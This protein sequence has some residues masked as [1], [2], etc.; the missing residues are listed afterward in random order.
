MY[1]CKADQSP[2]EVYS[3]NMIENNQNEYI[4][5]SFVTRDNMKEMA[6]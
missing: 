4:L 2:G 3:G 5:T 6:L 1:I